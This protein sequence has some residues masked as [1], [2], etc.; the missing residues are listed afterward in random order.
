MGIDTGEA[1]N[2]HPIDKKI[3]GE[4]LALL[5]LARHYQKPVADAGPAFKSLERLPGALKLRFDHADGGLV[6]KGD[7][8]G[9]FSVAG[10]DRQWHWAGATIEGDTVVV[11][12]PE[13]PNPEAARYAWQSFPVATL[14]NGSN[15]P[16]APFRTENWPEQQRAAGKTISANR[17]WPI[18]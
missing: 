16:A 15:L 2:I 7:K 13:V 9:E 14:F 1:D 10:K 12:S 17:G 3:V 4:R 8:L 18:E 6:V 5:A 11:S